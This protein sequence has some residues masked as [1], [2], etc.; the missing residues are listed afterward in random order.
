MKLF[1]WQKAFRQV[2]NWLTLRISRFEMYQNKYLTPKSH[3]CYKALIKIS[4]CLW[5]CSYVIRYSN[6]KFAIT[7]SL[8]FSVTM[9]LLCSNLISLAL[10][11]YLSNFFV[12][13]LHWCPQVDGVVC[14][15]NRCPWKGSLGLEG[16]RPWCTKQI[17]GQKQM[18][19]RWKK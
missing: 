14:D 13:F 3:K 6:I 9:C 4:E 19:I 17:C 7:N 15:R 8:D 16:L 5:S 18:E 11:F 10:N 2:I 1:S 12:L